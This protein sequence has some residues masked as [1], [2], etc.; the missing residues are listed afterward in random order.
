MSK[1]TMIASEA[2][3]GFDSSSVLAGPVAEDKSMKGFAA[4]R[5]N[6][7]PGH[8]R[9]VLEAARLYAD[10]LAG[11]IDPIFIK[12]AI[13]P[14]NEVFVRHLMEKYPGIYGDPGGRQLGLRETMSVTDYQA[15]YVDVL[16]RMYYGFYNAYP[17]VNKSLVKI[18]T[19][20]DF[21]LV[22]RY[23][24]DGAVTP[25]TAMDAAAPP[26]QKALFG[27]APQDGAVPATAATSTAPIQY[28]P[29]LYQSMTSVNWRAFVND[30]LGIFKDLSNRLAIQGNRGISKFITGFYVDANGPN[31]TLYNSGYG[32]LI[33]L[34]NGASSDNPPLSIQ[35]LQ[36]ACAILAGMRDSTGDPILITG[37]MILWY[38]PSYYATAMNLMKMLEVTVSVQ[39]GT[40]A[41]A[42]GFPAQAV[43]VGNWIVQNLQLVMD[44]YI[45]I[46]CTASGV[47]HKMWGI[48]IDPNS[49]NRPATEVGFLQ[50][51]ETPQIFQKVPNTMR[52]G[53]GV[54]PMMGDFYSMD[55]DM[56]I[57]GVMGGVNIDGRS[58][59][60][61][62][63]Q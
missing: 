42:T 24:L 40:Q 19:L 59:V 38:P 22:S 20:R 1:M 48:T 58:T 8:D 60:A 61:S 14:R 45:P 29:L 26:P 63:G 49:Q 23:L 41:G 27:P 3:R 32:N 36:D 16:D 30:D 43:K 33:N 52:M 25:Y 55:Q 13:Q 9:R 31:A 57:V 5:R 4:A 47:Q 18:H 28:Q 46:V 6:A 12:E 56:K 21:R 2:G 37:T 10:A 62:F 35:G 39:G 53:G 34:A 54:D 11:R 7:G 51:F 44:P 15:L 17:I 50:G